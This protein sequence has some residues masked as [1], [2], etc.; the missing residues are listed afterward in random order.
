MFLKD[1]QRSCLVWKSSR[2]AGLPGI[3]NYFLECLCC[4]WI[5]QWASAICIFAGFHSLQWIS[6]KILYVSTMLFMSS[7]PPFVC[8]QVTR[9]QRSCLSSPKWLSPGK[10]HCK[11]KRRTW[12]PTPTH[13]LFLQVSSSVIPTFSDSNYGFTPYMCTFSAIFTP[14]SCW[15]LDQALIKTTMFVL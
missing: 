5:L 7:L 10:L 14:L 2:C 11:V 6:M 8:S 12:K 13:H 15:L 3:G 1:I 4:W 9:S